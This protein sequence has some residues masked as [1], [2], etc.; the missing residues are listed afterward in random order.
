MR[1]FL[2][3]QAAFLALGWKAIREALLRTGRGLAAQA[4]HRFR[5]TGKRARRRAGAS[6]LDF[7]PQRDRAAV[8][9]DELDPVGLPETSLPSVGTLLREAREVAEGDL[10]EISAALRIR[11][12]HLR[13]IEAGD[14]AELPAP[15]YAI[16]FI[17]TYASL[18]GLDSAEMVH[19]FKQE[20]GGQH[21]AH[22]LA[23]PEPL[24]ERRLPL[25]GALVGLAILAL[26]AFGA[27]RLSTDRQ[28]REA[29]PPAPAPALV[30]PPPEAAPSPTPE[31]RT[32]DVPIEALPSLSP[33]A[34]PPSLPPAPTESV[35]SHGIE[36]ARALGPEPPEA[37][38][39]TGAGAATSRPSPSTDAAHVSG[40]VGGGHARI[41][42]R[43]TAETWLE[44]KD[45]N[46]SIFR[47]LLKPG[48]VYRLP[49]KPGLTLR[50]GNAHGIE[51]LADGKPLPR[52]AQPSQG[53]RV[54]VTL[55]ARELLAKAAM[56]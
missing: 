55:E 56:R 12:D 4:K 46:T 31:A 23:F 32:A 25:G 2:V 8:V 30:A 14:Y 29:T 41:A 38:A 54:L 48:D 9:E 50:I 47:R 19:R 26:C 17:R 34:G 16:G 7:L 51:V 49:Q 15:A 1:L 6:R 36:V 52:A 24:R 53:H 33:A 5:S 10:E 22:E 35:V 13:A 37:A 28:D 11:P 39:S 40:A 3:H 27:W 18:L 45:G 21:P 20:I 42:L 43:A 44:V